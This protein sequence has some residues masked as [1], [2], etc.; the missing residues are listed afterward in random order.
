MVR[1]L[2][3]V[4]L[5]LSLLLVFS[6]FVGCQG[7]RSTDV[8][9]RTYPWWDTIFTLIDDTSST[10]TICAPHIVEMMPEDGKEDIYYRDTFAF[11]FSMMPKTIDVAMYENG[12]TYIDGLAQF[13][14]D[15]LV[16]EP[17][18]P[19][20]PE[21][22][23]EMTIT[24]DCDQEEVS[25]V[26]SDVGYPVEVDLTGMTYALNLADATWKSPAGASSLLSTLLVSTHLLLEVVDVEP[27]PDFPNPAIDLRVATWYDGAQNECAPTIDLRADWDDPYCEVTA[28]E[29]EVV[30][31]TFYLE[32]WGF[33]LSGSVAP[34]GSRW[35]G[36]KLWGLVDTRD[37][38][39]AFGLASGNNAVCQLM[40]AFGVACVQC[41]DLFNYCLDIE[42]IDV[43]APRVNYDI[44]PVSTDD[45]SNNSE[46]D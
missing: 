13:E 38:A 11:R 28:T 43:D 44:I 32:I 23:Y 27:A 10:T 24:W 1:G 26:T 7:N 21:T 22:A 9:T 42:V 8:A 5:V 36:L 35:Q 14:G 4:R 15:W 3:C 41:P 16:W 6:L 17:L 30:T 33:G 31:D 25:W 39:D 20:L 2:S 18:D 46:C 40:G 37:M 19:L 12:D 45:V 34:D 29:L